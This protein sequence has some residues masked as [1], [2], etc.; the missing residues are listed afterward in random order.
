VA[1]L[2]EPFL[3]LMSHFGWT[4]FILAYRRDDDSDWLEL[5]SKLRSYST[6]SLGFDSQ[7]QKQYEKQRLE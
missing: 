6:Y 2:Y 7:G 4:D 1:E 3:A 5:S